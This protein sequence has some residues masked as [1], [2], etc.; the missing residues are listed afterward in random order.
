MNKL[1]FASAT[2]ERNHAIVIRLRAYGYRVMSTSD[3]Y[4]YYVHVFI[5]N[6]EK[7]RVYQIIEDV[8][9]ELREQEEVL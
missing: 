9:A 1:T 6:N 7:E 3:S 2:I 4:G 5:D 8:I